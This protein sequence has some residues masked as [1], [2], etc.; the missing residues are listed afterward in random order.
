MFRCK[1]ENSLGNLFRLSHPSQGGGF[2]DRL[3]LSF[4][5]FRNDIRF[6]QAWSYGIDMDVERTQF[7]SQGFGEADHPSFG[8]RIVGLPGR[9]KNPTDRRDID[10]LPIPLRDHLPNNRLATIE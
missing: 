9:A 3:P 6:D 2:D 10:D 8:G 1:K 4:G 5:H 7:P